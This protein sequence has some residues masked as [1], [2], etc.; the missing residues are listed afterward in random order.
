MSYLRLLVCLLM[1]ALIEVICMSFFSQSIMSLTWR[2][3]YVVLHQASMSLTQW[4]NQHTLLNH[5]MERP[6]LFSCSI[7]C[8]TFY[9]KVRVCVCASSGRFRFSCAHMPL[10]W[11]KLYHTVTL[12]P[13]ATSTTRSQTYPSSWLVRQTDMLK[14]CAILEV[15]YRAHERISG[16]QSTACSN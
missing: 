5:H 9:N 2:D 16:L 1:H 10:T 11:F 13:R 7:F 14:C 8:T 6:K 3:L 15:R 4:P 12:Q